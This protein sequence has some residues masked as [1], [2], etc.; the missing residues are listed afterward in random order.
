M[1]LLYQYDDHAPPSSDTPPGRVLMF[2]DVSAFAD[3]IVDGGYFSQGETLFLNS[4]A[5]VSVPEPGSR[6]AEPSKVISA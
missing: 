1:K 3:P 6:R 4:V 2:G 5:F